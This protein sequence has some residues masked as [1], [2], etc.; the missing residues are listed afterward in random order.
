MGGIS[1][2]ILGLSGLI[3]TPILLSGL[4]KYE[5]SIWVIIGQ[6][7]GLMLMTDL[8]ISNSI[9][10]LL[11]KYNALNSIN[12]K[13][14][15]Y[16]SSLI[17]LLLVMI[18]L[19][20]LSLFLSLFISDLLNIDEEFKKITTIVF[21]I[22]S[23]NV[24][25]AFP[26]RIGRGMLRS[27]HRFDRVDFL[28][29]LFKILQ[30][31][32]ISYFYLNNNIT[33]FKVAILIGSTN[34]FAEL[35][36]FING[37]KYY[38]EVNFDFRSI[39]KKILQEIFSISSASIL[40]TISAFLLNQGFIILTSLLLGVLYVPLLSIPLFLLISIGSFIGILTNT[41]IP[42]A[43]T[44]DS[45]NKF[46]D[47][48]KLSIYGF[49]YTFMQGLIF[50]IFF[51]AFGFE[52]LSI[53]LPANQMSA[54]EI[55]TI[56]KVLVVLLIP[57]ILAKSNQG[58]RNILVG[59]GE[60]WKVSNMYF[61]ISIFCFIIAILLIIQTSIGIYS[62]VIALAIKLILG[63]LLLTSYFVIKK[64]DV[65][66]MNYLA[67]ACKRPIVATIILCIIVFLLK[68]ISNNLILNF[69]IYFFSSIFA[70]LTILEKKHKK[71][72]FDIILGMGKK[73]FIIK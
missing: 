29:T 55:N 42:L 47:I 5:Y 16:S 59:I 36:I 41:F 62:I 44:Y 32:F 64:Y 68:I 17:I 34:F 63:D 8:G 22:M 66:I 25:I 65:N 6:M 48:K 21:L 30:I 11:S 73:I 35:V 10:R 26:L 28:I 23:F 60:H 70:F 24:A 52:L 40:L 71:Q 7:A 46:E 69:F 31:I 27:V 4:G 43:S 38:R 57:V 15:V 61:I 18:T 33:L 53:W 39:N 49:R 2:I 9:G 20:F 12:N 58:N 19:I 56:Y 51:Y 50:S 67:L 13:K 14:S 72:L 37:S 54:N 45:L 1:K 3:L